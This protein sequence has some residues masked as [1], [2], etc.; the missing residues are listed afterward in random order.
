[1][2]KHAKKDDEDS[3]GDFYATLFT[4]NS[5]TFARA[6]ITAAAEGQL[7]H[8]DAAHLLN[9]KVRALDAVSERLLGGRILGG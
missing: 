4:R 5:H 2:D 8:R 3:G 6:V 9:V 7:L 1:M